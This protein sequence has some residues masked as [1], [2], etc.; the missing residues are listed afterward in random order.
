MEPQNEV[1]PEAQRR[2]AQG[3]LASFIL[4]RLDEDEERARRGYYSDTH[5]EMFTTEAHLG[6][7]LAWR[8][9]FPREQWDV[10]ANDA[11]SEAARDAI[12][13]RITAHEADRTAR[14]LADISAKRH[15]V[16]LHRAVRTEG[17]LY[18]D[19]SLADPMEVCHACDANTTDA[20]WPE[21]P[22]PTLRRLGE[23]YADDH[24]DYREWWR[25]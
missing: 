1:L 7:W 4:A 5:W 21:M 6:A 23:P 16:I 10:K 11:I 2:S 25:P 18:Q 13:Q 3:F 19:G 12:R 17:L 22:C 20:D 8:Q 15:I 9:H 24:P 14:A